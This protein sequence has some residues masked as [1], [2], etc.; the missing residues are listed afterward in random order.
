[1]MILSGVEFTE[2]EL[3]ERA[4]RNARPKNRNAY[5]T[6]WIV[7]KSVFGVGSGVANALC[8]EFDLDPDEDLKP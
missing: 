7:I 3:L 5:K 1:M 6:R 8:R 2:R 4:V